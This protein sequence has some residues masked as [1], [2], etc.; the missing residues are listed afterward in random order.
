MHSENN[1]ILLYHSTK[2]D[3]NIYRKTVRFIFI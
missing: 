3:V 2:A 1:A